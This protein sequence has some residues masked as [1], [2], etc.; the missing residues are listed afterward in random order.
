M[1]NN[2]GRIICTVMSILALSQTAFSGIA[3]ADVVPSNESGINVN[4]TPT[5]GNT[6]INN[7][8]TSIN[9]EITLPKEFI[10]AL[11][12][13]GGDQNKQ[14]VT[15]INNYY[16]TNEGN[17]EESGTSD[18]EEIT[19]NIDDMSYGELQSMIKNLDTTSNSNGLSEEGK[20]LIRA[21]NNYYKE[22]FKD[23]YANKEDSKDEQGGIKVPSEPNDGV[24]ESITGDK[25]V[26][27]WYWY[28]N[29]WYYI[30]NH[31]LTYGWHKYEKDGNWY[32]LDSDTG[33]MR[34]GWIEFNGHKYYLNNT[35]DGTRGSMQT[36]WL[37]YNNKW[38]YLNT[39]GTMASNT[40]ID[41]YKISLDGTVK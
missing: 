31:K 4:V 27:G 25:T 1:I 5:V 23:K 17:K 11:L 20:E 22:Y 34:T 41:G 29:N 37:N 39:D 26:D 33:V 32:Y 10:D 14:P 19:N 8:N 35:S 6:S 12:A 16:Y 13:I 24:I 2:T 36:G 15:I 28:E 3:Y 38:Y 9:N 21:L 30:N 18:V 40:V 7:G